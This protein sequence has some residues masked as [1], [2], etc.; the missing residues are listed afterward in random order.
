MVTDLKKFTLSPSKV[1]TFYRCQRKFYYSYINQ[2]FPQAEH[3][4]FV[5]GNI[6]HKTLEFFHGVHYQGGDWKKGMAKSFRSAFELEKAQEKLDKGIIQKQ[7]LKTVKGMLKNYL[8]FLRSGR[9]VNVHQ[10]E[11]LVS[12]DIGGVPVWMK[13]DRV[14]LLPGGGYVVIDYKTSKEPASKAEELSSVQIPSYGLWMRTE[15]SQTAKLQGV[16]Y[17]L[18]YLDSKK[19]VHTHSITDAWL[20][21]TTKKYVEVYSQVQE[22]CQYIKTIDHLCRYCD[23]RLPCSS[24]FGLK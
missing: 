4:Y 19:G 6:A 10:L 13:A 7:D 18:R 14:D 20:T 16:Y 15:F 23:Y 17:Y 21:A 2:P 12:V 22:G 3:N 24:D 8:K 5:I 1:D 9:S 11:R